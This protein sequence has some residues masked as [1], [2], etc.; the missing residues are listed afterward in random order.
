MRRSNQR[1]SC[2]QTAEGWCVAWYGGDQR[3]ACVCGGSVLFVCVSALHASDANFRKR[4]RLCEATQQRLT[5]M[6]HHPDSVSS[7]NSCVR[8]MLTLTVCAITMV[9]SDVALAH[10]LAVENGSAQGRYL[11][12]SSSIAWRTV[13]DLLR[14]VLP[15]AKI[16]TEVEEGEHYL[17][18]L[19]FSC[20]SLLL[21]RTASFPTVEAAA[22]VSWAKLGSVSRGTPCLQSC[23]G[24]R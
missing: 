16:P 21:V 19:W 13:C 8:C 5:S 4:A 9:R 2:L 12:C 20:V 22:S 3:H 10:V 1:L 14:R 11:L 6:R 23:F 15:N 17:L 18:N 24:A 7:F